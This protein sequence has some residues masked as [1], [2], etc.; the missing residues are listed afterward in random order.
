MIRWVKTL[1]A[2]ILPQSWEEDIFESGHPGMPKAK[3]PTKRGH[4]A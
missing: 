2:K 1:L 4:S 3:Q